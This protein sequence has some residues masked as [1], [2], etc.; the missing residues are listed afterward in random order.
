MALASK[1]CLPRRRRVALFVLPP[2]LTDTMIEIVGEHEKIAYSKLPTNSP[3]SES[4]R[5]VVMK[6]DGLKQ[7]IEIDM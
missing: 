1:I 3:C 5:T 2:I 6:D 7:L 4:L